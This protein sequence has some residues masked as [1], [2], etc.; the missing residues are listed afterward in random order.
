MLRFGLF[1]DCPAS[2]SHAPFTVKSEQVKG[3]PVKSEPLKSEPIAM[4]IPPAFAETD[5]SRLHDAIERHSFA[6]LVSTA[7]GEIVASHLPLLLDRAT[8]SNGTLIGHMARANGQWR[9]AA[10][11]EVLTVFSGPHAYIS[12]SWY[13]A[14]LTVPTWNYIAVHAYG[15]LQLIDDLD[16]T[17]ALLNR[18][19]D[20]YESSQ[21]TP[22][23]LQESPEFVARLA[24][25]VVAFRIPITRLEG[26]WKLN[27][28]RPAEQ[29]ARVS[30]RLL[31]DNDEA[32]RQV[33]L[34]MRKLQSEL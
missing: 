24:A 2:L 14:P 1:F 29:R 30:S 34:E 17:I 11:A 22:W 19:V 3:E 27:Q 20:H 32:S 23:Q 25:Q 12:P 28:N 18:T 6:V 16:E 21:P 9:Q 33:G 8:G 5:L 15:R 10:D 31:D 4:Y 7:G 26:K 13:E